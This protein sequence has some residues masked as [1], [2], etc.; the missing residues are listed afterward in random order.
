MAR[1]REGL[2][3]GWPVSEPSSG[4]WSDFYEIRKRKKEMKPINLKANRVMRGGSWYYYA[5]ACRAGNRLNVAPDYRSNFLGCRLSMRF[6][7]GK[8]R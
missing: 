1:L 2:S 4:V 6:V 3:R 7:K 5:G 8:K